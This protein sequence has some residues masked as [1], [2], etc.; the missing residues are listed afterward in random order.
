MTDA[1]QTLSDRIKDFHNVAALFDRMPPE[2]SLAALR[3]ATRKLEDWASRNA[4][5]IAD[6][7]DDGQASLLSADGLAHQEGTKAGAV[8]DRLLLASRGGPQ[9]ES[10][11]AAVPMTLRPMSTRTVEVIPDLDALEASEHPSE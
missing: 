11:A 8:L 5:A 2:R 1:L 9:M 4:L 3:E 10:D 6:A 7:M